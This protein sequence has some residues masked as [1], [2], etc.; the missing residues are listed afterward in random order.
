M[1]ASPSIPSTTTLVQALDGF[2]MENYFRNQIYIYFDGINPSTDKFRVV[3]KYGVEY[4][5]TG[6]FEPF[7]ENKLSDTTDDVRKDLKETVR[8]GGLV[9]AVSGKLGEKF[10][11]AITEYGFLAGPYRPYVDMAGQMLSK[12]L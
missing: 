3:V 11:K 8:K 12:I 4:V 6:Q 9:D 7:I 2:T 10:A 5:P 1:G